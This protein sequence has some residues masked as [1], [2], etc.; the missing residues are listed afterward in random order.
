VPYTVSSLLSPLD[1]RADLAAILRDLKFTSSQTDPDVW[2]RSSGTHYNMILVY[3][4]NILI[5]AEE[6]KF[7]MDELGKLNE[8]KPESVKKP[9]VYLGANMEK[10]RLPDGKVK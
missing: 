10:V 8:L 7:T 1:E 2:L 9:N 3:V 6:P 4:N 5:F